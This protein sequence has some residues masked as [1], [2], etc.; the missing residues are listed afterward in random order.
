[1]IAPLATPIPAD[2]SATGFDAKGPVR[3]A[4]MRTE[5]VG[6][7]ERV[8]ILGWI[9]SA[10]EV[11]ALVVDELGDVTETPLRELRISPEWVARRPHPRPRPAA[12]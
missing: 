5:L 7:S 4:G 3:R 10:G 2:W 11:A 1:M 12:G 8:L 6:P 9:H